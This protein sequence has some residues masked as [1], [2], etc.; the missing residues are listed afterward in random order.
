MS[1]KVLFIS[2]SAGRTG[3][4]IVLLHILRWLRIKTDIDF[5]ILLKSH[6]V[7]QPEFE[8][9][10]QTTLYPSSSFDYFDRLPRTQ[11]LD[12]YIHKALVYQLLKRYKSANFGLIYSN[13][14]TNGHIQASIAKSLECPVVCHIHELDYWIN[15]CGLEN[16]N[17]VRY[18]TNLYIAV[19]EA[20][21]KNLIEN[22][23]ISEMK[24]EKIYGF[25]DTNIDKQKKEKEARIIRQTLNIPF[26][27][28][29]VGGSGTEF[30]RK[31]KDLFIQLALLVSKVTK[32]LSLHFVW[33]GPH[34]N[35]DDQNKIAHDIEESGL[36]DYIHFV[37][38]VSDP[39]NFYAVF[40]IFAMVSREDP[41]PLVCLEA[42]SLEKPIVCFDG[43]GGAPEFVEG[44]AG[45][46][47][48]YLDVPMMA[49]Y[50]IHLAEDM[51]LRRKMGLRA[52][53]K[54]RQRHDVNIAAP[55]IEQVIR[56]FL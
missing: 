50:V 56:S 27:A 4:P 3:A 37:G 21:K 12:L 36:K 48:P 8:A 11:K 19:S 9:L 5:E 29:V 18:C 52:S 13:T 32:N 55:Q 35:D 14:I 54:V 51:S 31:G 6:G 23:S 26:D 24:I 53:Q 43:A 30:W 41:F 39:F 49:E 17:K 15:K 47:V 42:A 38:E 7:L 22:Y 10:G 45:F 33:I 16:L 40:D 28:I 2:H 34:E 46:I 44:D 20:V 25:I 1:K